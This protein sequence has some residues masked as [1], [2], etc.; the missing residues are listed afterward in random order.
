M[1]DSHRVSIHRHYFS[2]ALDHV[3]E[4]EKVSSEMDEHRFSGQEIH[5]IEMNLSVSYEK[6]EK[7]VI[8]PI[9]FSAMCLEAF[10]YDYGA[11]HLGDKYIKENL[12]KLDLPSKFIVITKLVTGKDFAKG[13]H[14]YE[15]LK[16]LARDR[17]R[18]VHFKSKKF[19]LTE[20]DKASEFHDKLNAELKESMY[21]S[22][23][24]VRQVLKEIDEMHEEGSNF[25]DNIEPYQCHA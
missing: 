13:G 10:I 5:I 12:D 23:N 3:T 19:K 24:T 22:V 16:R 8:I 17:N 18:L 2:I 7:A 4:Y 14:A 21:K 6:R 11:S 1:Y 20:M 15:G 25:A 9:V